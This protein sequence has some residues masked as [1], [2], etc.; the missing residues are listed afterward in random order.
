M[1][2]RLDASG[3]KLSAS[4]NLPSSPRSTTMCGLFYMV[5]DRNDYTCPINLS[6]SVDDAIFVETGTN[7]TTLDGYVYAGGAFTKTAG[8][9][10]ITVGRWYFMAITVSSA[11]AANFYYADLTTATALTKV[12]MSGTVGT[13][14]PTLIC[15]GDSVFT[16]EWWNGRMA[17]MRAWSTELTQAQLEGEMWFLLAQHTTSLNRS[18]PSFAGSGERARDYSGNG[19]NLTEGGTLADEDDPPVLWSNTV[20]P[21][22]VSVATTNTYALVATLDG[23]SSLTATGVNTFT[24]ASALDGTSAL[25]SVGKNTF[26]LAATL[27]GTSALTVAGKNTFTSAVTLAGTSDLSALGKNTFTPAAT[28]DGTSAL[29]VV[30]KNTFAISAAVV[31][32]SALTVSAKNTFTPVSTLDGTSALTA[33]ITTSGTNTYN[34]VSTLAGTSLLTCV[35]TNTFA[36]SSTLAGTS[37][38]TAAGKNTFTP[39]STLDGTSQLTAVGKSTF[40]IASALYGTSTLTASILDHSIFDLQSTL[41]GE[42]SLSA[43]LVNEFLLAASMAGSAEMTV[44]LSARESIGPFL[45]EYI[46]DRTRRIRHDQ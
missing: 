9:L 21:V 36:G 2:S 5:T 25:T 35:G 30:G 29:T 22:Y 8:M 33:D 1:S 42:S 20:T 15:F 43:G 14:T 28:L 12:S 16:G 45:R 31:G 6:A 23:T 19:Y 34:L 26:A 38:L 24:P 13:W 39:D 10:S 4:T 32:S 18:I 3:D 17:G 27:A 46:R 41:S 11:G 44:T 7:G 40:A 37:A